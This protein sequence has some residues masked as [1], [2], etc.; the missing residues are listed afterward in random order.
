MTLLV[1]VYIVVAVD[2]FLLTPNKQLLSVFFCLGQ[3]YAVLQALASIRGKDAE[4]RQAEYL[5]Q[6]KT[7]SWTKKKLF[8]GGVDVEVSKAF[9]L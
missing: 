3:A 9:A 5:W 4:K 7:G 2:V 8:S 1:V 6:F